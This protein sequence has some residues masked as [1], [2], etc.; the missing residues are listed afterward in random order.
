MPLIIF[1]YLSRQLLQVMFAVASVVLLI[2][3]SGRFVN[4]LADAASGSLRADFVL[5]IMAYRVPE[6]LTMILPLGFFLGIILAYGR[7]CV[8]H[9]MSVLT[10][11]G[12][13]RNQLLAMT[14]VPGIGVMI[15]V[16][17]LS[18]YVAP[19]GIQ[20]VEMIF[21]E[22]DALTEFDTLVAGRFQSI[23]PRVTYTQELTDDNQ[24]L[25]GVFIANRNTGSNLGDMSLVLSDTGRIET[26][27]GEDGERFLIL[28]EGVRYDLTPG[29]LEMRET[30]FDA[31]GLRM[32]QTS[33]RKEITKEKAL[34]TSRLIG[35]D[36]L[37]YISELQWRISLPLLVPIVI[38][39]AMPLAMVNPRQGRYVK[40]LPSILMYL[41]YLALLMSARGAIE[42][43]RLPASIGLWGIHAL[44]LLIALFMYF[45]EPLAR[46]VSRWRATNA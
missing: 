39:L 1:R 2:I 40:L 29:Q 4:Y 5:L 27:Q 14:M 46:N 7:L 42:D 8:D 33:A 23:G 43:G 12:M 9:E 30:K 44:F 19:L 20:K 13:S 11:C 15:L 32:E 35:S 34:D 31:Y 45:Y 26:Q 37:T 22:Q 25:E 24:Q 16:G 10:S 28:R 36:S 41:F 18:L 3:M 17:F 6:F 38:L 21:A